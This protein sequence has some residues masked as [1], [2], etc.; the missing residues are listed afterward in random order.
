MNGPWR[1][2]ASSDLCGVCHP[3]QR[4]Q[5]DPGRHLLV[6]LLGL[7]SCPGQQQVHT[8][9]RDFVQCHAERAE[10]LPEGLIFVR[11]QRRCE[12]RRCPFD[13]LALLHHR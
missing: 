12:S 2:P 4:L 13:Y 6:R 1:I 9:G 10:R 7:I 8:S 5:L 11:S 3:E